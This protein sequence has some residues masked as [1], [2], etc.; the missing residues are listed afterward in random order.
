VMNSAEIRTYELRAQGSRK[1]GMSKVSEA[2]SL[3]P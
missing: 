3:E 2:L 1:I